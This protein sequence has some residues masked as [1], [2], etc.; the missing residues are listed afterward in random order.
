LFGIE[1]LQMEQEPHGMFARCFAARDGEQ[2]EIAAREV[3][4]VR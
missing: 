4:G 3:D 1:A 2:R